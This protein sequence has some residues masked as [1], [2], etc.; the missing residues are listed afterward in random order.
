MNSDRASLPIADILVVDDTPDNLRLLSAMLSEQGYKVRKVISGSLALKVVQLAPPDLILLDINMPTMNGYEVCEKLKANPQTKDIPVIFLSALGDPLDKVKAFAVGGGDY[1][2]KPFQLAEAL[3]RIEHQL[4]LC[5]LQKQLIEQNA[6]LQQE[7]HE[8]QKAEE[9]IQLLLRL[10]QTVNSAPDFATALRVVLNEVCEAIGFSYGEAWTISAN[11]IVLECSPTW[12]VDRAGKDSAQIAAIEQLRQ[13]SEGLTFRPN[14]GL[15]GRVWSRGETEWIFDISAE[16]STVFVRS[17]LAKA[18]GFK[19]NLGV[20][21]VSDP[22]SVT[23]DSTES[24]RVLAVLVFFVETR[25]EDK[26]VVKLV[27]AVANQLGRVMQQKQA[28]EALRL[29]EEKFSKAFRCSPDPIMITTFTDGR[30]I[31]VNDSFLSTSG[32]SRNEIIGRTSFELNFEVN[33]TEVTQIYQLLQEQA[34][35]RNQEFNYCTKSGVVRTVLLS[36]ELINFGGQTY[37]LAIGK[38]ITERKQVEEAL[39][40]SEAREREKAQE[41]EIALEKLKRAQ[42]QLIQTEKMSSL[43]QMIAGVAHEINN[44]TSFI[45]GNLTPAREYFQDLI[46]LI[47]A[48]RWTYPHP[49]PEIQQLTEEI[50]L[51]FLLEDWQKLIDSMQ[52]GS[53]RIQEIVLSLR[54]FSRLDESELK[55]VDIHEGIDNTL[56]IL[57]HRL[58]GVGDRPEITVIKDYGQLPKVICYASQLNQVFMNLLNNAIDAIASRFANQAL[59]LAV[60]NPESDVIPTIRI[61]TEFKT[62][63]L[64]LKSD[65]KFLNSSQVVIRIADN[66]PGMSEDLQNQIFNPFFTTKPMG[67]GTGLGLSITYQI[68]VEKHGGQ[69]SCVSTPGQGTEFIVEIPN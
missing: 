37:V 54:S 29:S 2:T 28:E 7:I 11:G 45:Y 63:K 33:P 26:R 22:I 53:Q 5:S 21:I 35:I 62:K 44:P 49:T 15:P 14:E 16:S 50:D 43:G 46:R 56:L 24:G 4:K 47:Q 57:E 30:Y 55:P 39:R 12:Y 13:H 20:P 67:S 61:R 41:L 17:D 64:M 23:E 51:E 65:S 19:T 1:I 25:Q 32:Y 18:C 27:N 58:R 66:G 69:L 8:R 60:K 52:M 34:V 36:A 6:L 38:D 59:D 68:V 48:Y 10:T 3:A 40:Q 9:E 42:S 31:E